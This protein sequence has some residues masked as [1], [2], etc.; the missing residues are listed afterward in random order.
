M[1]CYGDSGGA[2]FLDRGD[3]IYVLAGV[4]AKNAGLVKLLFEGVV[5]FFG[6]TPR[7]CFSRAWC[8]RT[9]PHKMFL[10]AAMC[11]DRMPCDRNLFHGLVRKLLKGRRR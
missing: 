10:E 5:A 4:M 3:G 8:W 1:L 11:G 7:D 9:H 2:L 6:H